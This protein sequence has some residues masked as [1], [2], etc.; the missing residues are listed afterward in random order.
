MAEGKG[1]VTHEEEKKLK[2]REERMIKEMERRAME[3]SLIYKDAVANELVKRT[4]MIKSDLLAVEKR[5]VRWP[6]AR[7]IVKK[8]NREMM[9]TYSRRGGVFSE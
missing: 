4:H 9:R 1:D 2:T 5:L 3:G 7:D 8:R 6:E